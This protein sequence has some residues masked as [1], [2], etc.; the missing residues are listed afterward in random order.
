MVLLASRESGRYK[1]GMRRPRLALAI[2]AIVLLLLGGAYTAVWFVAAGRVEDGVAEAAQS[3]KAQNLD[4]SWQG[5]RV[6]GYPFSFT[7]TLSQARLRAT[8]SNPPAELRAP[9]LSATTH[10]WNYRVWRLDAPGGLNIAAGAS[11]PAIASLTAK[12]MTGSIVA[13]TEGPVRVWLGLTEPSGSFGLSVSAR[14]ADLWFSLPP[15]PPR[16]H[17]QPAGSVAIL[18]REVTLPLVPPPFHNPVDEFGA[19]LTLMGEVPPGPPR[20]AAQAWRDNGGT[21]EVDNLSLHWGNIAASG[22]GTLAL[23]SEMQ[24]TGSFSGSV[25][26]YDELMKA[27]VAGGQLRASDARMAQLA[28]SFLAKP[29]PNG[30]PQISTS[31]QIQNGQMYMGPAKLG[32]VPRIPW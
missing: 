24:P 28:L 13:P 15:Q 16:E 14:Y 4:L 9:E 6:G 11:Q 2:A 32:P 1:A 31:F 26:G 23:D 18:A 22:S 10:P 7:V 19:G 8:A 3:L 25:E 5:I 21:L 12:D 27:L 20:Q 30:R 17:T 29:G